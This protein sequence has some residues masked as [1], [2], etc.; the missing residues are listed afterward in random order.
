MII[1]EGLFLSGKWLN[2]MLESIWT[3]FSN[4]LPF[5]L[6]FKIGALGEK[7]KF[8]PLGRVL[9]IVLFFFSPPP[10]LSSSL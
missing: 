1:R 3:N 9:E 7:H 5:F 6:L 2:N 10:P 8:F 4:P